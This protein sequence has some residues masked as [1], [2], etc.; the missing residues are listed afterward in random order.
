MR[1]GRALPAVAFFLVFSSIAGL[2]EIAGKWDS[3]INNC[4]CRMLLTF[5]ESNGALTGVVRFP[6]RS[7]RI[8]G[9][10]VKGH[11]IFFV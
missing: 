9:V 2:A 7:R 4:N 10:I 1:F 8:Y 11:T 5:E 3:T 6:G